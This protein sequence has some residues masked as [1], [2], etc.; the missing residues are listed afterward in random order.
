MP[1]LR[2]S[3]LTPSEAVDLTAAGV[4]DWSHFAGPSG[5]ADTKNTSPLLAESLWF[6]STHFPPT[7]SS[8]S[9]SLASGVDAGADIPNIAFAAVTVSPE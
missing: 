9:W 4:L 1:T 5:F 7:V 8:T 6:T 3:T 2:M